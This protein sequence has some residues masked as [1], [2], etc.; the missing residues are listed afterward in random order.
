M[1]KSNLGLTRLWIVNKLL[2]K[3]FT[4]IPEVKSKACLLDFL[5]D[6]CFQS[7]E[8]LLLSHSHSIMNMCMRILRLHEVLEQVLMCIG[9]WECY[10]TSTIRNFSW[11]NEPFLAMLRVSVS[12]QLQK[13]T[14]DQEI[15][16]LGSSLLKKGTSDTLYTRCAI[17]RIFHE[18]NPCKYFFSF[19]VVIKT[20]SDMFE[21]F[22]HFISVSYSNT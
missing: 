18:K 9:F 15:R 20:S 2:T 10:R 13:K 8:F 7:E 22:Q 19:K 12:L 4:K 21:A 14:S 3:C 17:W 11:K 16:F 5:R 6:L 1:A